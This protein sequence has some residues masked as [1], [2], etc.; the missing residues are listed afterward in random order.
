[1]FILKTI[2]FKRFILKSS[3]VYS[4]TS[5]PEVLT[6]TK[7]QSI[8]IRPRI[9]NSPIDNQNGNGSKGFKISG[10]DVF[11][12]SGV[13]LIPS[14]YGEYGKITAYP[15]TITVRM[16][17]AR[18]KYPI[19]FTFSEAVLKVHIFVRSEVLKILKLNIS[20]V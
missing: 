17:I 13:K 1:M 8:P 9:P 19:T 6:K 3:L 11:E 2:V 4:L 5:S 12:D 20:V 7:D 15:T 14:P 18:S 16:V 10:V